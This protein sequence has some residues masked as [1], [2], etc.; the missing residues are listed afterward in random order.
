MLLA[1]VVGLAAC[2]SDS[3][4]KQGAANPA[5]VSGTAA[6][7]L[8]AMART[9][10]SDVPL[11]KGIKEDIERSYVYESAALQVGRMVYEVDTRST[12][13]AQ[14]YITEAPK[15]GWQLTSMLQA[16][17]AQMMFQKPGKEMWV[18]V[19]PKGMMSK[20]AR[21]VIHVVPTETVAQARVQDLG[22]PR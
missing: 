22:S 2:Q 19:S 9:R 7:P 16:E 5:T 8:P 1:A 18:S 3:Y 15:L 4:S 14:F 10:F 12:N 6:S 13:V 11:P 17:G 21:L 20:N